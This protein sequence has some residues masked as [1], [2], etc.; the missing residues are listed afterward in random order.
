MNKTP[1]ELNMDEQPDAL[2]KVASVGLQSEIAQVLRRKWDR[3]VFTGMG[4]SLFAA[5]PIWQYL[6]SKGIPAWNV[7]AGVL[8]D[9]PGLLNPETLV[10]A[11]SQSGGSGEIVELLDRRSE[12]YVSCG[13]VLGITSNAQSSLATRA[14]GYVDILSGDEAT[15]S[16]KS[17]LNTL[18]TLHKMRDLLLGGEV[19]STEKETLQVAQTVEVTLAMNGAEAV[20]VKSIANAWYRLAAV[21]RGAD[22]ATATYAALITKEAAK[23]AIEGYAGGEFR[24]GPLELAGPGMTAFFYGVDS[25]HDGVLQRLIRD[26]KAT[27]ADVVTIGDQSI[28]G[29]TNL[30]AE[31]SNELTRLA[32]G[33]VVSQQIA[34]ALARANSVEPG[35]FIYGR[36]VTASF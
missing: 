16:T 11:I 26:T 35:A 15:V 28:E 10:I 33:A 17:Y 29:A 31:C 25:N 2:R 3:I 13:Y 19:V 6:A 9:C 32:T 22:I 27:G 34:V 18:A 20:A 4:S 8:V 12:K 21:A 1:F 5:H 14:D 23:V 30:H 36:K 7:D 24:H